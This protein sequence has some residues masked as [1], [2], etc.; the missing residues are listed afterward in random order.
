MTPKK[1]LTRLDK[2][3]LYDKPEDNKND[4]DITVFLIGEF[5]DAD[6]AL[7]L[8]DE[9]HEPRSTEEGIIIGFLEEWYDD[10][11]DDVD[12]IAELLA[13]RT[14]ISL[15][16]DYVR[17]EADGLKDERK[18]R[19]SKK[20][21]YDKLEK[22]VNRLYAVLV[23]DRKLYDV[24]ESHVAEFSK[25]YGLPYNYGGKGPRLK[26]DPVKVA[27]ILVFKGAK[28]IGNRRLL[29]LLRS[30]NVN[31]LIEE[32][33]EGCDKLPSE[34][35]LRKV[36]GKDE[37][38]EWLDGFIVWLLLQK[39]SPYL[40]YHGERNYVADGTDEKTSRLKVAI[41]GGRKTMRRE[42]IPVKFT[43]NVNVNM[44]LHVEITTSRSLDHVI[45]LLA[46]GDVL[47]ADSEFLT[48][49]NCYLALVKGLK[50][51]I[52]PKKKA[53]R[54]PELRECIDKF[55]KELYKVR[56]NGERGAKLY[57][58]AV[59]HYV[60]PVRRRAMVK[61]MAAAHNIQRLVKLAIK[62]G[63]VMKPVAKIKIS[64]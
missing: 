2:P 16:K 27:S 25:A 20:T 35:L 7:S 39:A 38:V 63:I 13:A 62:Y 46:P 56:K 59:M 51:L 57:N 53:K 31:A 45:S 49:D 54:S 14:V 9:Y 12:K 17:N 26:Y 43:Y 48:K 11:G 22:K 10:V 21:T 5:L 58:D 36:M 37:F 32:T 42:T 34:S 28:Q 64:V 50:V 40:A 33:T 23:D 60:N 44:Y 29:A 30:L 6:S 41:K 47:L 52:K 8:L 4:Y 61:L 18:R 19:W 24:I 3:P 55:D 15:V 1:T